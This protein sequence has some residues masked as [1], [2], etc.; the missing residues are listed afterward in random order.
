MPSYPHPARAVRGPAVAGSFYPAAAHVLAR[1]VTELPATAGTVATTHPPKAIIA[2]HAG[3]GYSGA[4]A[5][6]IAAVLRR[7]WGGDETLMIVSSDLAHLHRHADAQ[8]LDRTPTDAIRALRSDLD[9][10]QA[11]GAL[12]V[13]GLN[14]LARELGLRATLVDRCN[15]GDTC[16]DISR[17]VGYASLAYFEPANHEH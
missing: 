13:N 8:W 12:P 11:C 4:T 2:P 5:V 17:V 14:L 9:P 15:C 6:G 3:H 16:G 1:T 7:L 10:E